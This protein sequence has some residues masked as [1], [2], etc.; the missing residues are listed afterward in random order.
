MSMSIALMGLN[1]AQAAIN[2]TSN[3][4]ANAGTIGY[5]G[6][7]TEFGDIFTSSPYAPT[8][9][10]SGN[11]TELLGVRRSFQQ[12]ALSSTGNTLD[13]AIQGSGFF[14]LQN[15]EGDMS[16][17]RAGAFGL[18]AGGHI[19]N[20]S[21]D[22]LMTLPV[23]QNGA[24]LGGAAPQLSALQVPMYSGTS[25]ATASVEMA[26]NLASGDALSATPFSPSD[27]AS[28]ASSTPIEMFDGDGQPM[29]ATVYFALTQVPGATAPETLYTPYVVV[30]GTTLVDPAGQTLGF[31]ADG[32]QLT[33][34]APLNLTLPDG[35]AFTLDLGGSTLGA[36]GFA[37]TRYAHDGETSE[38]LTGLEVDAD[39]V[40]W[41]SYGDQQAKALGMVAMANFNNPEGLRPIGSAAFS[42]TS[43]S[44]AALFG[45]AN[46]KGM[47]SL[48]SAA[49]ESSNIDLTQQM[50][51][52]IT[53]QRNYQASAKA[54]ETSSSLAQTII[55][56]RG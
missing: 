11:G 39:G 49:L 51:D 53:S 5:R 1:A 4:I 36:G 15:G 32:A 21:G 24:G 38:M 18:D 6:G 33:P 12:G 7:R 43:D 22:M 9:T 31:D 48:R 16:Y 46:S 3:N 23:A 13:L 8:N 17:T 40:I 25:E 56:M 2:N 41:A 37:V 27:P 44:G 42:A 20:S 55:N 54:L 47:G 19:V 26:V 52:L 10:Q 28:Y 30:D 29:D 45:G 14:T 34:S 50:V 35:A